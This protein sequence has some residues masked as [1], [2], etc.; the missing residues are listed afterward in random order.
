MSKSSSSDVY[1][2]HVDNGETFYKEWLG[3]KRADYD[4]VVFI[5]AKKEFLTQVL[6]GKDIDKD[7]ITPEDFV[8][9]LAKE[10]EIGK[11]FHNPKGVAY[12]AMYKY[13][14]GRKEY[15]HQE[16]WINGK[17]I[18]DEAEIKKIIHDSN[19]ND[20]AETIING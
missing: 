3:E 13:H 20:K 11:Y 2:N 1:F 10:K 5:N 16:Y 4:L 14:D 8:L 18:L 12:G 9:K 15:K 17:R 6:K 19:F 7:F